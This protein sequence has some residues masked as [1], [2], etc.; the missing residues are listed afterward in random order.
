MSRTSQRCA[1]SLDNGPTQKWE[2]HFY[3]SRS[4]L[5]IVIRAQR[6]MKAIK[7]SRIKFFSIIK[8][9]HAVEKWTAG[10]N[11]IVGERERIILDR[12]FT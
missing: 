5:A 3:S 9:I 8:S 11:D 12:K 7:R 2:D 6:I 1:S 4:K 10:G